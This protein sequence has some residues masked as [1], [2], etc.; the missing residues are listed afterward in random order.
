[1][2]YDAAEVGHFPVTATT[3]I[4]L[5]TVVRWQQNIIEELNLYLL[6]LSCHITDCRATLLSSI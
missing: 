2:N 3:F 6:H 5:L 4:E 1:M